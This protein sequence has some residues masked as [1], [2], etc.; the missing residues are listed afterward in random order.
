MDL[1]HEKGV[2]KHN[3]CWHKRGV[4]LR[5]ECLRGGDYSSCYSL[6]QVYRAGIQVGIARGR[7]ILGKD[8]RGQED[9]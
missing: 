9:S 4:F 5:R 7:N 3:R 6:M 2:L 1:T 8:G